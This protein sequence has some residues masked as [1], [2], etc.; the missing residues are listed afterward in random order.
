MLYLKTKCGRQRLELF[1]YLPHGPVSRI[2]T[3][4]A[5]TLKFCPGSSHIWHTEIHLFHSH[6]AFCQVWILTT[7]HFTMR[8]T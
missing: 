1:I 2:S 6:N 7:T 3:K 8:T 5:Q 4:P